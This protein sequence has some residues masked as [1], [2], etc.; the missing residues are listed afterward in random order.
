[1]TQKTNVLFLAYHILWVLLALLSTME[2]GMNR[3]TGH[4]DLLWLWSEVYGFFLEGFR[5]CKY[6]CSD[7]AILLFPFVYLF[8]Y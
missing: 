5:F 2:K 8:Y 3:V 1:V 7:L 6:C 4:G